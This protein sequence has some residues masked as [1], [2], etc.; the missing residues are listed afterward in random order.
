[1]CLHD[2]KAMTGSARHK[3]RGLRSSVSCHGEHEAISPRF[4]VR[5]SNFYS[6]TSLDPSQPGEKLTQH[7]L[8]AQQ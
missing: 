1:M 3:V 6:Y 7:G 4:S 5:T 2:S 8:L